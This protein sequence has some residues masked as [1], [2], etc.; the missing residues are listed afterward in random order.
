MIEFVEKMAKA[1]LN[2]SLDLYT[3]T[4]VYGLLS[5]LISVV[6]DLYEK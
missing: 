6:N 4:L 5:D 2:I 1:V 3:G